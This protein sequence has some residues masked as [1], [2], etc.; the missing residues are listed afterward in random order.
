MADAVARDGANEVNEAFIAS[1][2][3]S[4]PVFRDIEFLYSRGSSLP[5]DSDARQ[6]GYDEVFDPP[7][8]SEYECPICMNCLRDPVQTN[9]GHRFCKNCIERHIR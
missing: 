7:V 8:A 9:C 5:V 2:G 4:L 6:D 3:Q 1:G